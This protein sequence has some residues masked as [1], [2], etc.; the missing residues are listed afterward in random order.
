MNSSGSVV[1]LLD[2]FS[3]VATLMDSLPFDMACQYWL[4]VANCGPG[5]R[6]RDGRFPV[7]QLDQDQL[8]LDIAAPGQG[9]GLRGR[10]LLFSTLAPVILQSRG[11]AWTWGC[12]RQ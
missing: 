12:C 4:L 7:G 9:V 10:P 2:R 6:L 5:V 11:C 3:T 1:A 8:H